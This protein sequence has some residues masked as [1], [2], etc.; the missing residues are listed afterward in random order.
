M[1]GEDGDQRPGA[2]R[3]GLGAAGLGLAWGLVGAGAVGL[4][5]FALAWWNASAAGS[6]GPVPPALLAASAGEFLWSQLLPWVPLTGLAGWLHAQIRGHGAD[7]QTGAFAAA[8]AVGG[9][10]AT[11]AVTTS[12]LP[13]SLAAFDEVAGL[14]AAG[15]VA[16]AVH[17]IASGPVAARLGFPGRGLGLAAAAVAALALVSGVAFV[18]SPLFDPGGYRADLETPPA[19]ARGGHPHVLWIVLDTVRADRLGLYGSERDTT[20]FLDAWSSDALVFDT[21]I[22]DGTWTSP[23]HASMFTGRSVREH[24][25]GRTTLVLDPQFPTV[26]ERLSEAGYRTAAF[27]NNPL[28]GG[29]KNGLERGFATARVPVRLA[30]LGRPAL[31]RWVERAGIPPML[32]WLDRDNGAALTI[33]LAARWLEQAAATGEP[34]FLFVNLVEAH[35]PWEVPEAHRRVFLDADDSARSRRLRRHAYGDL[36]HALNQRVAEE[37]TGFIAPDDRRILRSQYDAAIHYLDARVGELVGFFDR[38]GWR[39]RSVVVVTSDHGEY[40]GTHD[41]WSHLYRTY[42]DLLHVPLVLRPVGGTPGR[43]IDRPVQLSDLHPTLIRLALGGEAGDDAGRDLVAVAADDADARR[44]VSEAGDFG[45]RAGTAANTFRAP[46][47]KRGRL[48]AR[49][50]VAIRGDRFKLVRPEKGRLELYDLQAD[51]GEKRSVLSQ[52]REEARALAAELRRWE[53]SRPAHEP[54]MA[55]LLE[56]GSEMRRALLELGYVEE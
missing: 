36:E 48:L 46:D 40:L 3:G 24:G 47:T 23:S 43:R 42:E 53:E 17:R 51:P 7:G 34:V 1:T 38:L 56:P 2:R 6:G 32:P 55:D 39:D 52:H 8:L 37:G 44:V 50:E 45:A 10:G 33:W 14:V 22:A 18:R 15:L 41:L 27:S 35:L 31:E 11:W 30:G 21:A 54:S 25:V 19:A 26:A 29:A 12:S 16:L 13:E 49:P 4:A 28:I 5:E 9:S 20:P